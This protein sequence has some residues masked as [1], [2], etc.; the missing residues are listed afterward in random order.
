MIG[1]LLGWILRRNRV[2]RV[3]LSMGRG[4]E[5]RRR[6]LSRYWR[7]HF[8]HSKAAQAEW[9]DTL[10]LPAGA[11]LL[12]AG[13]G[14]LND[15]NDQAAR[16][17]ASI[18][19]LDAD[20]RNAAAWKRLR[21]RLSPDVGVEWTV[22]DVAGCLHAWV[23][24]L[25]S[26]PWSETLDAV[27]AA[28]AIPAHP[29]ARRADAV[30]SLSLLS[31]IPIAWQDAVEGLLESRFGK[32]FVARH[33][34]EWLAAVEPGSRL[35]VERHLDWLRASAEHILLIAD[36]EYVYYSGGVPYS[37][38]RHRPPPVIWSA[39]EGWRAAE[40]ETPA[41]ITVESALYGVSPGTPAS[42][43]LWHIAPLGLESTRS[44]T[45]H[46]VGAIVLE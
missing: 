9:I 46:R 6:E 26:A 39:E 38:F 30:L 24:S 40:G 22:A 13:A 45:V 20:R 3:F 17:F 32:R 27:R 2:D 12:V 36:L 31:Q 21:A 33:E 44:G 10:P 35:L 41:T 11:R 8:E 43:W 23:A 15:F 1:T 37:R 14:R 5:R 42:S 28:A 18:E 16:R 4:I 25:P 7:P 34:S 19:L 29:P